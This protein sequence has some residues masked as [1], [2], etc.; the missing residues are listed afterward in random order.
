MLV[1][2]KPASMPL[3][4]RGRVSKPVA[5]KLCLA[6]YQDRGYKEVILSQQFS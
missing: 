2:I 4:E 5:C 1:L 6:L 3:L